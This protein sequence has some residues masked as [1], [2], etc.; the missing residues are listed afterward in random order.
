MTLADLELSPWLL[1]AL[2]FW[3]GAV[4]GS[5]VNVVVYRVPLDMSV[6]RPGSHCPGCGAP[7]A[8]YDNIP[9]LSWLLLRGRARCCKVRISPRYL[10]VEALSGLIALAIFEAI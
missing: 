7:V 1:R 9:I 10:V 5:F 8:A 2:A 6:V 3:W 4:W